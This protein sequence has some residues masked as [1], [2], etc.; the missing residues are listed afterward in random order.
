MEDKLG[1]QAGG[2][3]QSDQLLFCFCVF[4]FWHLALSLQLGTTSHGVLC[5]LRVYNSVLQGSFLVRTDHCPV[6]VV[7]H[8]KCGQCEQETEFLILIKSSLCCHLWLVASTFDRS[9]PGRCSVMR[10]DVDPSPSSQTLQDG[11]SCTRAGV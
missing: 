10:C 5:P 8:L 6:L 1:E 4:L 2:G 7:K 9:G 11:V 3:G